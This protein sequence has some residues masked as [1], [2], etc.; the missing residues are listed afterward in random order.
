MKWFMY[1]VIV[2]AILVALYG[3]DESPMPAEAPPKV[4]QSDDLEAAA[5][6]AGLMLDMLGYPKV[7]Y[8]GG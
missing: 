7:E 5:S 6:A 1:I 8:A 2:L 4:Q 3:C